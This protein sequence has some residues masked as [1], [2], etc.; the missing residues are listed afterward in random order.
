M[1][2][3]IPSRGHVYR[4]HCA[5]PGQSVFVLQSWARAPQPV[6]H[7][8]RAAAPSGAKPRQHRSSPKQSAGSSHDMRRPPGQAPT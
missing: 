1:W 8:A 3:T 2:T 7:W 4:L 6:S 5:V